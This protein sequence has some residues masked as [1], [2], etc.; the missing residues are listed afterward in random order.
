LYDRIA[1]VKAL[2]GEVPVEA[3]FVSNIGKFTKGIPKWV[4]MLD[5]IEVEF[6]VGRSQHESISGVHPL[7]RRIGAAWSVRCVRPALF[8]NLLGRIQPEKNHRVAR[9]AA[10]TLSRGLTAAGRDAARDVR[11]KTRLVA[12]RARRGSRFPRQ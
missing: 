12:P 10:A 4:L 8:T 6:P 11:Q 9:R 2:V 5:G 3:G 7:R 1:A